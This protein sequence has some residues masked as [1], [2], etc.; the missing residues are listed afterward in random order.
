MPNADAFRV[1]VLGA[2]GT[3]LSRSGSVMSRERLLSI[4]AD[5]Q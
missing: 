4:A 1:L 5:Q 3:V 2:N